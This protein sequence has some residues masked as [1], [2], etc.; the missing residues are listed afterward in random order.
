MDNIKRA[1]TKQANMVAKHIAI[2]IINFL[3]IDDCFFIIINESAPKPPE[4]APPIAPPITGNTLTN[5][6]TFPQVIININGIKARI[7]S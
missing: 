2:P 6:G 3:P 7:H 5:S 1:R 4:I